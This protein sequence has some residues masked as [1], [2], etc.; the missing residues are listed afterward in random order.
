M[1]DFNK[2]EQATAKH[3]GDARRKGQVARSLEISTAATVV[4]G[5]ISLTW[6][7]SIVGHN[8]LQF[9]RVMFSSIR[10]GASEIPGREILLLS[11]TIG[12]SGATL[13]WIG[14]I[15]GLSLIVGFAQVGF[16]FAE[17]TWRWENLNPV[18][19][20]KRL[21][22]WSNGVR[23]LVS[24]FKL[25]L[26]VLVSKGVIQ[27]ALKSEL[28]T[29]SASPAE[30][31][32]FLTDTAL[33]LGWRVAL[34]IGMIAIADYFYQH[35]QHEKN[36]RMTKE[37]VKEEGKQSEGDPQVRGK[38][39]ST[40]LRRLRSRMMQE[41]P[42]ATV[43]ITNPTHVA[44]A[45]RYDRNKMKAPKVVAKGLRLMAQRIKELAK[46][47]GVPILENKPLARGLYKHSKLGAEIPASYFQAVAAILV[48]VYRLSSR[49]KMEDKTQPNPPPE[50]F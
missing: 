14:I 36:L 24:I 11:S 37:E 6:V 13:M 18:Q 38:I 35:W 5:V 44:V 34:A 45:L 23:A 2:S 10:Y 17:F 15:L 43:I 46:E 30:L 8:L 42:K 7:G 21:F 20:M 3:R 1:D 12:I 9:M 4:A 25:T 28:L 19:G 41:I 49:K 31:V 22:S 16:E 33:A 39:R 29:R 48:Q 47:H 27:T 32:F 40:M 26:I 50:Y